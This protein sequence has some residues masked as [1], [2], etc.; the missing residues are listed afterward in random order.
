MENDATRSRQPTQRYP[1]QT[2]ANQTPRRPHG[3]H[4]REAV[5]TAYRTP[6][7]QTTHRRPI[8]PKRQYTT[9]PITRILNRSPSV[10]HQSNH[11]TSHQ[12]RWSRLIVTIMKNN[13]RD[14]TFDNYWYWTG[15]V[16]STIVVLAELL[17]LI[18][19]DQPA[20]ITI[21][22]FGVGLTGIFLN[23]YQLWKSWSH[24]LPNL[25]CPSSITTGSFLGQIFES[26]LNTNCQRM[27]PSVFTQSSH[28]ISMKV[29]TRYHSKWPL[30]RVAKLWLTDSEI[31]WLWTAT[32]VWK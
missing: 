12:I 23:I 5:T 6:D 15:L 29:A 28:W 7:H 25:I 20:P 24:S 8:S 9:W 30:H 32:L 14:G 22:I 10:T 31:R 19:E 13:K 4:S 16:F 2:L 11:P 18:Y 26:H 3:A 1:G 17:V 21:F 27:W